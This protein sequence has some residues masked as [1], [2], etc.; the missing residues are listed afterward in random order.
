MKRAALFLLFLLL[1]LAGCTDQL[2]VSFATLEGTTMIT[3]E[4]ADV[5]KERALGLMYRESLPENAGMLF[6]FPD[7]N[8]RTFWMKNVK[9]SIDLIFVDS[10]LN[11]NEVKTVQPCT[12]EPCPV[13]PSEFP[14]QY[15]IEVNA[16]FAE[17]H[18]IRAGT[19]VDLGK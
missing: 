17:K 18:G 9:F 2:T 15:V 13:Y 6:I 4:I 16:G 3:A 7:L 19:K 5:P 14:A 11:V 1:V 8:Y 12:A 10:G